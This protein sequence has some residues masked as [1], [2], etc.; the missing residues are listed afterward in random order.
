MAAHKDFL[1]IIK[2][3]VPLDARVIVGCDAGKRSSRA[4]NEMRQSGYQDVRNLSRGFSVPGY[5]VE[6]G[7]GGPR[8]Y[9]SLAATAGDD[10]L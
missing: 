10:D 3:H 1:S 2:T 9:A 7:D 4:A 5:P 8:S 6:R